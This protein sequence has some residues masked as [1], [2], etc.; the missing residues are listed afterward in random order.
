MATLD[1]GAIKRDFPI[2]ALEINGK[3]LV[4]LDS[5]SSSQKPNAVLDA[6][7]DMYRTH[8]ANIHRGVYA[9]AEQATAAYEG[10]RR[11]VARFVNAHATEEIIF[12]RNATESINLVA[13]SWARANLR[14]GDVIVLSHLEHH[15]NVV[16]WQILAAERGVQLRWIPLT[17][18]Y[19]L[20]MSKVDE[21]LDG[22]KLLAISAMSNVLGTINDVRTLT[23]A[24]RAAGAHVLV[25]ACQYVPHVATDVREWDA[26]FVA[27][28]AHKLLGPTGIGALWARR[29]LLEE[30]PPFLGGGEMIRDVRL[31]GF[32]PN[33]VP[34][35]FEAGTMPIVE[36]IG[37]GAAVDYLTN[38]GMDAV[39]AHEMQLTEYA[40]GALR[41]RFDESLRI[42]GPLDVTQRGGAVSFL[43]EGIHA[44]DISQVLD[45]DAVCVRAGHH[46][47]KPLMRQLGVPA[48]SRASFYVY[49]DEAD[50][51]AL[52]EALAK[53]QKFFEI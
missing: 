11:K 37:F 28:S 44:H 17:S 30:M 5:A 1:V 38:L 7:D 3:R 18:D 32:T 34:W 47:A 50:V 46:C 48:T 10:A 13:Y 23:Q 35:K 9:I 49:N 52:V 6:M 8:Y 21:L 40:L 4:Y 25:D 24:A 29:E 43:F 39:R 41:D 53:A 27:F 12:T 36:A 20:D 19:L 33:D 45:E 15:A 14:E 26:D 2:L 42:Y 22:A 31:D 51:D 16:P